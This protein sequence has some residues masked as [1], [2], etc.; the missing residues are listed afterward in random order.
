MR[1]RPPALNTLLELGRKI[2][3]EAA[4]D[5]VL[6]SLALCASLIRAEARFH[7]AGREKRDTEV[8]SRNLRPKVAAERLGISVRKLTRE[9]FTTYREICIPIEGQSRGYVVSEP[10]LE[11]LLVRQ[12][13]AR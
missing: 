10:A 7:M 8:P 13:A 3:K 12:R 11:A 1:S 2:I 6:R 9:R 4:D 5:R